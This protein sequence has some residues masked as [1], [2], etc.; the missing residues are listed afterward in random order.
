MS[1]DTKRHAILQVRWGQ[2]AYQKTLIAPGQVLRVGRAPAEGLGLPH[3]AHMAAEQFELAWSGRRAWM[4]D[5]KGPSGTLLEGEPVEHGEVFNGSWLRAGQTDFSVYLERTTPPSP[6]A[7]PDLPEVAAHKAQALECLRGQKTPLYAILDAARSPR[8][9][10]LLHESVEPYCS[11]YEGP[12]GEALA[13]MAPYLVS[14]PNKDSWLLE[15]LVQEGWAAAWGIYLT[16]PLPVLQVR[17]HFR[18]LLM[19]EAESIEGRLYFRF[20]DP[21]V[22]H[23]FLPTCQP[24]MKK[25]F[26]GEVERFILSGT[27]GEL[28]E[29]PFVEPKS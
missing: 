4:H 1:T 27:S 8:I 20:Y 10:E 6:P 13:G 11:L 3:D 24:D 23:I 7:Q 14:L 2:M 9:L 17:R 12:K 5:L 16:S 26:F 22:L 15:A 28:V 19:V 25:E 29:I 21:R 18:K